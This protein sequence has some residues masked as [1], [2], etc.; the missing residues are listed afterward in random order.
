MKIAVASTGPTLDHYVGSRFDH[1]A[2]ILIID[3]ASLEYE[4]L[5]NPLT[6]L[7]TAYAGGFF[8]NMLA[9]EGVNV[10]LTGQCSAQIIATLSSFGIS[11]IIGI[12]G[13]V[14]RAIENFVP[15]LTGAGQAAG[16]I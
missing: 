1:A 16:H 15:H 13:S 10:I 3:V 11:A 7:R 12:A 4:S 8:M 14:R 2:Y 5:R 9:S 6:G